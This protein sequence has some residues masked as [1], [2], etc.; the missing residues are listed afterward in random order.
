MALSR[1]DSDR[2]FQDYLETLSNHDGQPRSVRHRELLLS[3]AEL[4]FRLRGGAHCA[5]CGTHVR[6]V[7]PVTVEHPNHSLTR[8]ACLCLRCLEA[9]RALARNVTQR[10]G[11]A[12]IVYPGRDAEVAA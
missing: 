4:L 1:K 12:A 7:L 8:Y 6:H 2:A 9:E 5:L 10:I 3:Y 11:E